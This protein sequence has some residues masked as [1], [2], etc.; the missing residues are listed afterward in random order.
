MQE[1]IFTEEQSLLFLR[2]LENDHPEYRL[3]ETKFATD[4]V[5]LTRVDLFNTKIS[6]HMTTRRQ[7]KEDPTYKHQKY[8][9]PKRGNKSY[10]RPRSKSPRDNNPP[11]RSRSPSF[12]KRT[13]SK[14]FERN[15]PK[16]PSKQ[17]SS[18]VSRPSSRSSSTSPSRNTSLYQQNYGSQHQSW[19]YRK[20]SRDR[21]NSGDRNQS[22]ERKDFRHRSKSWSNSRNGKI[23]N[24]QKKINELSKELSQLTLTCERCASKGLHDTLNCPIYFRTAPKVCPSCHMG[25]HFNCKS[26]FQNR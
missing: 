20:D 1:K 14:S 18:D 13:R 15:A 22:K 7:A 21:K 3:Q 9:P 23:E 8:T 16:S 26:S 5:D 6:S 2:T 10:Q 25:K 17:Y 24:L 19:R 11:P 4:R 12:D